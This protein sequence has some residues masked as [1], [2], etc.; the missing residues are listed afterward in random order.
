MIAP[1]PKNKSHL[2]RALE[3]KNSAGYVLITCSNPC[4]EG[5]MDVEMSYDGD[6][7]LIEYLLKGAEE[8][9]SAEDHSSNEVSL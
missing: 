5:K 8:H 2:Q 9:F 7:A 4:S 6:R 3:A 1:I